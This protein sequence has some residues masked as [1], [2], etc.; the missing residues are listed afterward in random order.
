MRGP[1]AQEAITGQQPVVP[2]VEQPSAGPIVRLYRCISTALI[3]PLFDL[4]YR[5]ITV[6]ERASGRQVSRF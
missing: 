3:A 1:E 6:E 4:D 5:V 2:I